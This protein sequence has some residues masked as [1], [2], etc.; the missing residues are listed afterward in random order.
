MHLISFT[1]LIERCFAIFYIE[2]VQRRLSRTLLNLVLVALASGR[3]ITPTPYC[4]IAQ[5]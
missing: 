3:A 4:D 2:D 1:S 5:Q